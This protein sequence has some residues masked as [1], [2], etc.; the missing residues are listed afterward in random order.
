M[1]VRPKEAGLDVRFRNVVRRAA[2]PAGETVVEA[3][4]WMR[5]EIIVIAG[6]LVHAR[7]QLTHVVRADGAT[8]G[9]F[10]MGDPCNAEGDQR[11]DENQAN[12]Q[13]N[14]REGGAL[15]RLMVHERR[16][17]SRVLKSRQRIFAIIVENLN[18]VSAPMRQNKA[19]PISF[20]DPP[21][22]SR[23]NW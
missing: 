22:I 9:L 21:G 15:L 16:I 2:K 18:A 12:H 19:W 3:P 6:V 4:I 17:E 7:H 5:Q 1:C 14:V 20:E 8:R 13:L 23:K 10:G 11:E